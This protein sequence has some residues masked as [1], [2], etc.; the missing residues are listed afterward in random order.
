V[1]IQCLLG[2]GKYEHDQAHERDQLDDSSRDRIAKSST[3]P[4]ADFVVPQ[5]VHNRSSSPG[6]AIIP[7]CGG[8]ANGDRNV[9]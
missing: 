3:S 6:K 8:I 7:K 1:L 5:T 2:N 4:Q 9:T